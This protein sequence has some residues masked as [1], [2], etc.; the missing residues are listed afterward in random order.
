M[1][2]LNIS[3][4]FPFFLLTRQASMLQQ[5]PKRKLITTPPLHQEKKKQNNSNFEK[6]AEKNRVYYKFLCKCREGF[7][8]FPEF[9]DHIKVSHKIKNLNFAEIL[10][11]KE[12]SK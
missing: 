1:I 2:K 6:K 5:A 3:R 4:I 10:A 7:N 8:S 11:K 9:L 12:G